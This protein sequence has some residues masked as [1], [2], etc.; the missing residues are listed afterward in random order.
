MDIMTLSE[1]LA[2]IALDQ[3]CETYSENPFVFEILDKLGDEL[4][5]TGH[6]FTPEGKNDF[7]DL[8]ARFEKTIK[9]IQ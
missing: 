5:T 9:E 2:M 3:Y 8:V 6:E 7:D 4:S 1:K